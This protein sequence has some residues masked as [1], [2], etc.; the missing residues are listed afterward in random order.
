MH[1]RSPRI[2]CP[3]RCVNP[4]ANRENSYLWPG[5]KEDSSNFH[6]LLIVLLVNAKRRERLDTWD[7]FND[8]PTEFSDLFRRVLSL[9]LDSSLSWTIRTHLMVFIIYA[10]QSL[11]CAIV[12]K[13]CAPLVSI[14][15]WHNLSTEKKRDELL[16][17]SPQL[18]KAWRAS[19]KRFDAADDPTKGRIRFERSWLYTA[20]LD[21]LALLYTDNAKPG[22]FCLASNLGWRTCSNPPWQIK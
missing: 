16:D 22:M 21:L 4:I 15:I 18:R 10:F 17:A 1:T 2:L 3:R 9:T 7:T 19:I 20:V 11:D 6:V 14:G 8:R 13:E 12:R 5:Y